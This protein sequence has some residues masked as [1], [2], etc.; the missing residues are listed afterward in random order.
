MDN[1]GGEYECSSTY[2]AEEL[3]ALIK[4]HERAE[5]HGGTLGM[6]AARAARGALGTDS[7]TLE[8]LHC[9]DTVIDVQDEV[10]GNNKGKSV[11]PVK[12]DVDSDGSVEEID[13]RALLGST[14]GKTAFRILPR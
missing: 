9:Q 2:N 8:D 12:K 3:V 13:V 7:H 11:L 14:K 6:A 4:Y 1:F 5:K 10:L